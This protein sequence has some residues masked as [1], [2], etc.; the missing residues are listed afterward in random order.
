MS[1]VI[2]SLILDTLNVVGNVS[3]NTTGLTQPTVNVFTRFSS[4]VNVPGFPQK[5]NV[6]IGRQGGKEQFF[7]IPSN[8]PDP[9]PEDDTDNIVTMNI[10]GG[11]FPGSLPHIADLKITGDAFVSIAKNFSAG[12]PF[13][14]SNVLGGIVPTVGGNI[15]AGGISGTSIPVGRHFF[16]ERMSLQPIGNPTH[17]VFAPPD[18]TGGILESSWTDQDCA[19]FIVGNLTSEGRDTSY[20]VYPENYAIASGT[21]PSFPNVFPPTD[22][23]NYSQVNFRAGPPQEF[24]IDVGMD[25]HLVGEPGAEQEYIPYPVLIPSPNAMQMAIETLIGPIPEGTS[26]CI[27]FGIC[28]RSQ[29]TDVQPTVFSTHP[30]IYTMNDDDKTIYSYPPANPDVQAQNFPPCPNPSLI[31][32]PWG[33]VGT[34]WA[35]QYKDIESP[36]YLRNCPDVGQYEQQGYNNIDALVGRVTALGGTNVP[37]RGQYRMKFTRSIEPSGEVPSYDATLGLAKLKGESYTCLA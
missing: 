12:Q 6:N 35:G 18:N 14:A 17:I 10:P 30:F 19:N 26:M 2:G 27:D 25:G 5:S 13:N 28:N 11:I 22:G 16:C 3:L 8:R 32:P 15:F 37:N 36:Y 23:D 7:E 1:T 29:G 24:I 4:V 31:P 21:P 9:T 33:Q 20:S 34:V